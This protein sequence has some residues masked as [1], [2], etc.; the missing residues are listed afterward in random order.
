MLLMVVNCIVI[1]LVG[2][3]VSSNV[4]LGGVLYVPDLSSNLLSV[5]QITDK[6]YSVVFQKDQCLLF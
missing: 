2:F 3:S 1:V 4:S 5:S 6:G